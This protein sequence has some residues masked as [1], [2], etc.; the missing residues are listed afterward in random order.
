MDK[1]DDHT[2]SI[3]SFRSHKST[4]TSKLF[5]N[6]ICLMA[7]TYPPTW[8]LSYYERFYMKIPIEGYNNRIWFS[9]ES[10]SNLGSNTDTLNCLLTNTCH[11]CLW[12]INLEK[13]NGHMM[14]WMFIFQLS[15]WNNSFW[16]QIIITYFNWDTNFIS[17][18][19]HF[20][21]TS[22]IV[23]T[24]PPHINMYPRCFQLAFL[25]EKRNYTSTHQNMRKGEYPKV[26]KGLQANVAIIVTF[27]FRALMMPLN[28]VATSVKLAIPPP[29]TRALLRPSGFAVAHYQKNRFAI[30]QHWHH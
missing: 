1:E 13:Q 9:F 18:T 23:W 26:T 29:T 7:Y 24:S 27:S 8:L 20:S 30:N 14:R 21:K 10:L 11:S 3:Y 4:Q 22:L 28:V 15:N 2:C 6:S 17:K 16:N 5:S 25:L 19:P 12:P